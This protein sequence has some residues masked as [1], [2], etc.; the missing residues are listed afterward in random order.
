MK[1]LYPASHE[2]PSLSDEQ[3]AVK[4]ARHSRCTACSSCPGLRP[5][6]G[7]YVTLDSEPQ[8]D[9]L[10][11]DSTELHS[12]V[13]NASP[14]YLSNCVCGHDLSEHGADQS[15]IDPEEFGRRGRVAVRADEL[16]KDEDKLLDFAYTDDHISGLRRQMQ[17]PPSS[18]ES[19][20][21][22][23]LGSLG[24]DAQCA[25]DFSDLRHARQCRLRQAGTCYRQRHPF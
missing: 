3:L 22:D 20:I 13:D 23:A 18:R 17:I 2:I 5:P 21:S 15:S 24:E 10:P 19:S 4:I 14:P 11:E 16:L 25:K 8:D 12:K 1:A 6:P 7:V 9:T